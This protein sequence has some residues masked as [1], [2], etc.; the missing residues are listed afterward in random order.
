LGLRLDW[1]RLNIEE[2]D[3]V[4]IVTLA[5]VYHLAKQGK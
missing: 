3:G 5:A 4:D 2:S 1:D